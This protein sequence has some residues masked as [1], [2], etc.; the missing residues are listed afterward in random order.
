MRVRYDRANDLFVANGKQVYWSSVYVLRQKSTTF[1]SLCKKL[2]VS[3]DEKHLFEEELDDLRE[4]KFIR[5]KKKITTTKKG[6][7][8]LSH[9]EKKLTR[10]Q[11][12]KKAVRDID[13][14][15]RQSEKV[16]TLDM[17]KTKLL[18]KRT[19]FH[20]E[21]VDWF[22][23]F[24]NSTVGLIIL[25]LVF[26]AVSYTMGSISF[27]ALVIQAVLSPVASVMFMGS[28]TIALW[29]LYY[30]GTAVDDQF[31]RRR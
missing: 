18:V 29:L 1:D 23:L 2:K 27:H 10:A 20:K 11:L 16:F 15:Y 17:G 26:L 21:R 4:L 6:K 25:I 30:S 8:F 14:A 7:E 12:R 31:F 13:D 22:S 24:V 19:P 28:A 5:G 9:V 3:K